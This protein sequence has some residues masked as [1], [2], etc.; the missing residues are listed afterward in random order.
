[1]KNK[2]NPNLKYYLSVAFLIV[3]AYA[4]IRLLLKETDIEEVKTLLLDADIKFI[5]LGAVMMLLFLFF[6]GLSIN[7]IVN[8]LNGEGDKHVSVW[9]GFT[10]GSI[11]SFYS[12]ITP[13]G[14]GGQPFTLY[15]MLHD[16]IKGYKVSMA[17]LMTLLEY[18]LVLIVYSIGVAVVKP[19]IIFGNGAWV[20]VLYAFS[21]I[22]NV[23]MVLLIV[24]SMFDDKHVKNVGAWIFNAGCKLHIIKP[25]N[26][27]ARKEKFFSQVDEYKSGAVYIKN[28][29]NIFFK[30]FLYNFG[31]ITSLFLVSYA[32]YLS[33]GL[34][35]E[36]IIDVLFAQAII[37]IMVDTLPLPGGV[38]IT[39]TLFLTVYSTIYTD[40][41]IT[42]A[43]L[44]TRFINYA[45]A[46]LVSGV[47]SFFKQIKVV[48]G[49]KKNA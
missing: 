23:A 6:E 7:K 44:L 30:A 22:V 24:V 45:W 5:I 46:L 48:K 12:F 39:E 16:G 17:M 40:S 20:I 32:V 27:E 21:L 43:V 41:M 18:K 8:S 15:Y 49:N 35:A 11:E 9:D 13:F 25:E 28:N 37:Y 47:I 2:K 38:G 3:M 14:S 26:L 31:R 19:E 10:Y 1:M 33:F 4:T 34:P 29:P 42:P 36:R